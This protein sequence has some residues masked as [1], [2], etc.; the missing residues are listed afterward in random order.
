[1]RDDTIKLAVSVWCDSDNGTDPGAPAKETLGAIGT[2]D[3]SRVTTMKEV[4]MLCPFFNEDISGWQT[5]NVK[6]M[7][8][9]FYAARAFNQDI[10]AWQTASVTTM[11]EAFTEA[12][13][14]NHALSRWRTAEV[15]DM[16]GTFLDASAFN[17]N[18]NTWQT[19]SVADMSQ[20]LM[21]AAS[22]DQPL[23][24]WQTRGLRGLGQMFAGATAFDQDLSAW[25]VGAVADPAGFRGTFENTPRLSAC[26]KASLVM[27]WTDQNDNA[28]LVR[29][30]GAAWSDACFFGDATLRVAARDWCSNATTGTDG[31]VRYML[32][33]HSINTWK[34]SAVK[35]MDSL[36]A[37]CPPKM[38]AVLEINWWRTA[39]VTSMNVRQ[40]EAE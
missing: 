8:R 35:R 24:A 30:R 19:D 39:A 17:Q 3:T 31:A 10:N 4:F 15:T 20:M 14:F 40:I 29:S 38:A 13:A 11:R 23:G 34:T 26:N 27:T 1:M 25:R 9:M 18:I 28:L 2:W 12:G 7:Q 32:R 37:A 22:F 33:N 16:R 21:R 5:S 6:S 36:F